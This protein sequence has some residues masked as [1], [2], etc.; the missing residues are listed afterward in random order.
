MAGITKTFS[1]ATVPIS[2]TDNKAYLVMQNIT[3]TNGISGFY[4]FDMSTGHVALIKNP[5]IP[6]STGITARRINCIGHNKLDGFIYGYRTNSNQIIKIDANGNYDLITVPGLNAATV[7]SATAGAVSNNQLHIFKNSTATIYK[8]NLSTLAVTTVNFSTPIPI[9]NFQINDFTFGSNGN[10]Y[11][12]TQPYGS[13][14]RK[15]FTINLTTNTMQF[16]GDAIGTDIN[17]ETDNSWG[18]TFRDIA[19]NLYVGNN[20]SRNAYKFTYNSATQT[21][22][23][24]ASLFSTADSLGQV[25]ADG[26]SCNFTLPPNPNNDQS[27]IADPTLS[28]NIT[29]NVLTNDVA[30]T[31]AIDPSSVRLIDPSTSAP[32]TSV[33]IPGQGTFS[34]N[35]VNGEISFSSLTTFT[36]PVTIQYTVADTLSNVSAPANITIGICY[37]TQPAASGT[38]NSHT[39]IG[40][41]AQQKQDAWPQNIPN[42]F[43]ALESKEK[44]FVITRVNH[45]ST[46]PQNGDSI[47]E[48]KEGMIV[49]DIQDKCV[50]LF[51]GTRWKCINRS[52]NN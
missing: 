21:Y 12:I 9:T 41:T 8:I 5:I 35:T 28:Q 3:G 1:Q 17:S 50:K 39:M 23:L 27:C 30:G 46:A 7:G 24:N 22:N 51:N 11:G 6:A 20:G 25:L 31:Y 29:F 4:T 44:G 37:C 52:C 43:I 49:Y 18:T 42:G 47:A 48:P 16:L 15:L 40:I 10:I 13:N 45:V 36:Q 19:D 34:V 2:C 14:S 38:P 32:S 33:T 26:A